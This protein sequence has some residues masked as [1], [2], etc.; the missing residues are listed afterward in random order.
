MKADTE[1]VEFSNCP[2]SLK[3][4]NWQHR[5]RLPAWTASSI[6]C[7]WRTSSRMGAGYG[8][9][10][11]YGSNWRWIYSGYVSSNKVDQSRVFQDLSFISLMQ[12]A[13]YCKFI[14]RGKFDQN[15]DSCVTTQILASWLFYI[16]RRAYDPIPSVCFW[17]QPWQHSWFLGSCRSSMYQ[18]S[19]PSWKRSVCAW[20][21]LNVAICCN[22]CNI[23]MLQFLQMIWQNEHFMSLPFVCLFC[24]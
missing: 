3:S 20:A 19:R 11:Q 21:A 13:R 22:S 4:R 10:Q 8:E 23:N 14:F 9:T 2:T 16:C 24:Y 18:D 5:E 1:H 17:P 7:C 12:G 15:S 6:K